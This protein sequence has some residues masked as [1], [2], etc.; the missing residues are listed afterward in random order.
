MP[1]VDTR[2]GIFTRDGS[3]RG[4]AEVRNE[5]GSLNSSDNPA[6]RGS[7][8]VFHAT[9]EGVLEPS[10][11]DG[12]I[13]GDVPP[14]PRLPVGVYLWDDHSSEDNGVQA[15][16]LSAREIPGSIPGVLEVRARVPEE[17]PVG[18]AITLSIQIGLGFLERGVTVALR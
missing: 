8:I 12:Q 10:W 9:G 2:P 11:V 7:V 4:Q 6:A 15:E 18:A 14:K 13:V 17:A 16:V 5:D 1:V 3:G